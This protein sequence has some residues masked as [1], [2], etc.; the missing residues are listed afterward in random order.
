MN[1]GLGSA[2]FGIEYGIT[3]LRGKVPEASVREILVGAAEACIDVVDTAATY[4]DA[5]EIIGRCLPRSSRPRLVTKTVPFSPDASL[6][7]NLAQAA[8]GFRQSL[9]RLR[10]DHVYGLLAH[11][12]DDLL[13]AGGDQLAEWLLLQRA[14]GIARHVGVS[15]Y[16]PEEVRELFERY[17]FDLIQLPLNVV[18]QRMFT[19]GT[20]AWLRTRPVEVHVRSV[21]LQGLLLAG[22][23][24]LTGSV[25]ELLP[26]LRPWWSWL[27]KNN[28]TPLRAALGFVAA[29]CPDATVIC[30]ITSLAE[31]TT[32][33]DA[34]R[35]PWGSAAD[36]A[37][38]AEDRNPRVDPRGWNRD[39]IR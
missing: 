29:A 33:A 36:F 15:V 8:L 1:L 35:K 39:C 28:V 4:G 14:T 30:G 7:D 17:A 20:L 3:N 22:P 2:Q 32:V 37:V 16:T 12:A 25:A 23:D 27:E 9:A 13:S 5:E 24:Q 18:N 10:V 26:A 11:N 31:L 19:G 6:E 34:A 21:F 38:L